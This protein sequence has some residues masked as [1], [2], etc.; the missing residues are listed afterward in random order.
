ML[1]VF[2]SDTKIHKQTLRKAV[3]TAGARMAH[4][5]PHLPNE[6]HKEREA[7]IFQRSRQAGC[8]TSLWWGS[9]E[10]FCFARLPLRPN[11]HS[12]SQKIRQTGQWKSGL[13][14]DCGLT[15]W[16]SNIKVS[17]GL[18]S[19]PSVE[20]SWWTLTLIWE[21]VLFDDELCLFWV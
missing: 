8:N 19:F 14:I 9:P 12:E 17:S 21:K 1:A 16:L 6:R 11:V 13:L 20:E 7:S 10:V 4:F 18:L 15:Q 2:G 5:L 3:S